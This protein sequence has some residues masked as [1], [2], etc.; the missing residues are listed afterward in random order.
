MCIVTG[1]SMSSPAVSGGLALLY[2]RY[3]QLHSGANPKNGLMKA[4]ICN[5]GTDLGNT[6]PDFTYGFGWMNLV[7]ISTN[8]REQ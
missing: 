1:T 4:L 7:T 2:Q 8:D 3:R 5:G 6:G